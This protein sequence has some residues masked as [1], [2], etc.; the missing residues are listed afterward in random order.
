MPSLLIFTG[1][2]FVAA[3]SPGSSTV[4][5]VSRGVRDVLPFLTAMLICEV[6]WLSLAVWGLAAIAESSHMGFAVIKWAGLG[7]LIWLAWKMWD[8]PVDGQEAKIPN[9]SSG[10]KLSLA[11]AALTLGNPKIMLFYMAL[12]SN[13]IDVRSL[14]MTRWIALVV[15]TLVVPTAAYVF[16]LLVA[17]KARNFLKTPRGMTVANCCGAGKMAGAAT[18]I[19]TH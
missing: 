6:I 11:G 5:I 19:A 8:A 7:Y 18:A 16:W 4:A 14:T 17:A 9:R 15:A 1:A 10:G 12:L 3:G 13:I 2:I